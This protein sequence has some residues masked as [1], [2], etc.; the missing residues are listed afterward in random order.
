MDCDDMNCQNSA[1]DEADVPGENIVRDTE[2]NSRLCP[3]SCCL[4]IYQED[5]AEF[6]TKTN[7]MLV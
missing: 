1:Q 5:K 4:N 7:T 6:D 2:S 3:E